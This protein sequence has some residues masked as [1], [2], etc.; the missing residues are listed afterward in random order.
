MQQYKLGASEEAEAQEAEASA[1]AAQAA[2][3][4]ERAD[5]YV[6]T[7]V[8]FAACLFFAGLSTRLRTLTGEAAVLTLGCVLF[9]GTVVW[10]AAFPVTV[11]A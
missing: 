8:L 9:V 10:V 7:V 5:K 11:T 2:E 4:I 3:D 6:L 1:A